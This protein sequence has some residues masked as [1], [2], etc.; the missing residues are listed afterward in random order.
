MS[1]A[2]FFKNAARAHRPLRPERIDLM[3][4]KWKTTYTDLVCEVVGSALIAAALYNFALHSEFPMTG[5]SGIALILRRL[6]GL[7]IGLTTFAL[8]IP[9]ML[10]C[11][12]LIGREFLLKSLRCMVIST[13]MIDFAAPLF[14]VYTGDRM[15]SALVTGTLG[16]I[17]YAL[18]YMRGSSTGGSDFLVMAAKKLKP[19]IRLGMLTFL[20][21]LVV[22]LAGSAIFRDIDG[23]VYGMVI[24]FL[25]ALMVDRMLCG[26]NAGKVGLI[27]TE[28][29]TEVCE[30]IDA[31]SGRGSTILEARGGYRQE[32]KQVVMVACSRKE[33]YQILSAVKQLD[34]EA[35]MIVMDSGEVHGQGFR[36]VQQ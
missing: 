32:E 24:N 23:A 21:D 17:G 1:R 27:V 10:A 22:V 8:N 14:P 31:C 16:G 19:H 20:T 28:R 9:V 30:C 13:V 18:I 4:L 6:F 34:D 12:R 29:A 26:L 7:P 36:V 2:A 25:T 11:Y 5:F 15:I 35:F 3:Q 33:M